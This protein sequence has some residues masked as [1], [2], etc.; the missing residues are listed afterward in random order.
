MESVFLEV[1]GGGPN[2]LRISLLYE[3]SY[4]GN[5]LKSMTYEDV[6]KCC[7]PVVAAKRAAAGTAAADAARARATVF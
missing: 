3:V 7:Q 4:S 2:G 1:F 6:A 5:P